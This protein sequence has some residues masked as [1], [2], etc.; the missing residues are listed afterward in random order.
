MP[1]TKPRKAILPDL[2]IVFGLNRSEAAAAIGISA[3][4]F[5]ELVN[6]GLL[7]LPRDIGGVLSWDVCELRDAYRHFPY[8][9]RRKPRAEIEG[10]GWG[11]G[12]E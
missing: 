4:K 10:S 5:D 11:S 3:T 6:A 12:D 2:P 8:S 1:G 7:P 9:G